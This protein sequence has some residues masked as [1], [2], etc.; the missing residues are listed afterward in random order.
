M[1]EP[2]KK[3]LRLTWA[4]VLVVVVLRLL[5]WLLAPALP[6]LLALAITGLVLYIAV[7]GW[8]GL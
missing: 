6:L 4:A 5:T 7:N 8:R 1:S 3:A 2:M